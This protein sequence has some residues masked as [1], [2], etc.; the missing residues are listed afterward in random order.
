MARFEGE[1][2][3][4]KRVQE[5]EF[6]VRTAVFKPA[7]A[8]V[9]HLLQ[10]AADRIDAAYAPKPGE[11]RKGR[12]RLQ[13]QG[14]FGCFD[15]ERDYYYHEGKEQ[16]HYPSDAALGLEVGYTPALARL[17]IAIAGR[18]SGFKCWMRW[19]PRMKEHFPVRFGGWIS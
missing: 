10:G 19:K 3:E 18:W 13:V 12:Q 4:G 9:G 7:N 15:L 11:Q 14:L 6:L 1:A 2:P 17:P 5:L 16:G 8:L